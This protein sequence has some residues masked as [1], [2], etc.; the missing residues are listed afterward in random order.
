LRWVRR[1]RRDRD[2][3]RVQTPEKRG[4]EFQTGRVE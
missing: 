4:D 2:D 1:E 3:T